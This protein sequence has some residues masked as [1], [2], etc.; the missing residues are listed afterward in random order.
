M[1]IFPT[2]DRG[3]RGR[4]R[5]IAWALAALVVALVISSGRAAERKDKDWALHAPTQQAKEVPAKE[6]ALIERTFAC[7]PL[8]GLIQFFTVF[9]VGDKEDAGRLLDAKLHR[10]DCIAFEAGDKVNLTQAR[11]QR[12]IHVFASCRV[13]FEPMLLDAVNVG[14]GSTTM[15]RIWFGNDG[16]IQRRTRATFA[17]KS[18]FI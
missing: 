9:S 2:V 7:R 13:R 15:M 4:L 11:E 18:M 8:A 10:G 1:R 3:S 14:A 6:I 5:A 17:D 16:D 12:A